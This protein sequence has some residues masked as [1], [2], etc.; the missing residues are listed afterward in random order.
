MLFLQKVIES[1]GSFFLNADHLEIKNVFFSSEKCC[2]YQLILQVKLL[3]KCRKWSVKFVSISG[4]V[5]ERFSDFLW[6]PSTYKT[7]VQNV[8][9]NWYVLLQ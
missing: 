1:Q 6:E 9:E 3:T 8:G 2:D 5:S 7:W 4:K